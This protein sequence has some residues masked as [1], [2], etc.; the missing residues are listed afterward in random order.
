MFL[1]LDADD[2]I[3]KWSNFIGSDQGAVGADYHPLGNASKITPPQFLRNFRLLINIFLWNLI[4]FFSFPFTTNIDHNRFIGILFYLL[5]QKINI[6]IVF[7]NELDVIPPVIFIKNSDLPQ[8]LP[9][10]SQ[11]SEPMSNLDL[12]LRPKID[13]SYHKFFM[14]NLILC[15]FSWITTQFFIF[16]LF[17]YDFYLCIQ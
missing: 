7:A 11:A 15:H 4:E 3:P 9:L 8:H 12:C 5:H 14:T 17:Y 16:F 1:S 13:F 10:E 6:S 2:V